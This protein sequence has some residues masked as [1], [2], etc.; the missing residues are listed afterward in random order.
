MI[1]A[2]KPARHGWAELPRL[3]ALSCFGRLRG[4]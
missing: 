4:R 2:P 1:M 3:V